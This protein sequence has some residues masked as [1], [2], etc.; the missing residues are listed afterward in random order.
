M[1][2]IMPKITA[3][4][5]KKSLVSL[6][7]GNERPFPHKESEKLVLYKT[8]F[9]TLDPTRVYTEKELK[10]VLETWLQ[11]LGGKLLT[12]STSL[13]RQLVDEG[14]LTR[15]PAGTAY[16]VRAGRLAEAFEPE[17]D[18]LDPAAVLENAR[19]IKEQKRLEFLKKS[20]GSSKE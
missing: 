6:C 2:Y 3:E 10:S 13:R 12:D 11:N 9:R 4:E 17:V 20:Q 19:Q 15:D 1:A 8:I 7:G 14:Y 18:S 16:Q 5:F